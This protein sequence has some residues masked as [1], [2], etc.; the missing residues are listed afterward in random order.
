MFK[1][2]LIAFEN[3][4]GDNIRSNMRHIMEPIMIEINKIYYNNIFK[5]A[6]HAIKAFQIYEIIS[7]Q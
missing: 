6:M 7:L 2:M 4:S 1:Y 5:M 3:L